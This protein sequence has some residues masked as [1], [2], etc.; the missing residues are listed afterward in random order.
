MAAFEDRIPSDDDIAKATADLRPDFASHRVLFAKVR[1]NSREG[2]RFLA[3]ATEKTSALGGRD[4]AEALLESEN[5]RSFNFFV[6]YDR[7][8][9]LR[10]DSLVL[11]KLFNNVDPKRDMVRKDGRVVVDACKKGPM[12]GHDREWPEDLA[13]DVD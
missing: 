12:D 8:I 7:D 3:L 1:E 2:N 10:D 5:L 9:D 11:W 13:F 6:L 4:I